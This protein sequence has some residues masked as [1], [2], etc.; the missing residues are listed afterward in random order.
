MADFLTALGLMFVIE[1]A[2]YALFPGAMKR[3]LLQILSLPVNQVRVF[4]IVC[5]ITGLCII[6][7]LKGF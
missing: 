1:G 2:V 5:A 3:M 6:V 7:L 4:G